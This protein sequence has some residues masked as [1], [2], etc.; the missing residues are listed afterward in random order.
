MVIERDEVTDGLDLAA[1]RAH[2]VD[3]ELS[4]THLRSVEEPLLWLSDA[5][6]WCVQR[7]G[8]WAASIDPIMRGVRTVDQ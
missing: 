3:Q 2:V 7:G 6:A 1:A 8:E 4:V 5:A